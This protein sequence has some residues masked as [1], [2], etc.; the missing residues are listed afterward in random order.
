MTAQGN[1]GI[2]CLRLF[3]H[4]PEGTGRSKLATTM[5]THTKATGTQRNWRTATALAALA[6][7]INNAA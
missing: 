5:H 7:E 1:G 4:L 6:H 2:P 3:L